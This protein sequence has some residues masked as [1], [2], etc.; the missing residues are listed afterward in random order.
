[1]TPTCRLHLV[2]PDG[3][4]E[5][6]AAC[7]EAACETGD[8]ASLVVSVT[9]V[10]AFSPLAVK[11]D[12]AL[13]VRDDIAAAFRAVADGVEISSAAEC[14]NARQMLTVDQI[15][16]AR[17][18]TSRHL[19]MEIAEAGADYVAFTQAQEKSPDEPI[20]GWWSS[21]FEI[22]CIAADPVEPVDLATLLTQR[23]DFIRPSDAMWHSPAECRVL[24]AA[25]MRVIAERDR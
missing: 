16:G 25:T 5:S 24:I 21:L 22:P 1:M 14:R 12:V 15:V 11:H 9:M 20:I 2:A 4:A 17:C 18:G 3:T 23:P 13:I 6:I 8:V 10:E 7:F 19:A